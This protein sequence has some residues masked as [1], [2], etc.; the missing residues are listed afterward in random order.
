M[1]KTYFNRKKLV[2]Y[3]LE[4]NLDSELLSHCHDWIL[5]FSKVF[6]EVIVYSTHVGRF[7]LPK[8]VFVNPM[9]GGTLKKRVVAA[10]NLANSLK[11]VFKH[12]KNLVV[13]HHM[14][15]KTS[16]AIGFPIKLVG[17]PQGLWYSHSHAPISL[18]MSKHFVDYIFSSTPGAIP[19]NSRKNTYVGHA[20]AVPETFELNLEEDAREGFVSL[21]RVVPIKRLEELL[22]VISSLENIKASITFIG[23]NS[24]NR[25]YS[26]YLIDIAEKK[27][28]RLKFS[29]PIHHDNVF[30]SLQNF[31]IYFTG[32]PKSVDKATIEAAI[33]GCLLVTDS[34][35]ALE[36]TGMNSI[37]GEKRLDLSE[38]I[39]FILNMSTAQLMNARR[40]LSLISRERNDLQKTILKMTEKL[41]TN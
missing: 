27:D 32:T 1:N 9:G 3:N 22:F 19:I 11:L 28:L 38:Q 2:I 21:G 18:K 36:L 29:D 5:E 14:S 41:L 8:N 40:E 13:F 34:E 20:I 37:Y 31:S 12:R 16:A 17:V 10:F 7:E 6:E 35:S 24:V 4:T 30:K 23:S 15:A 33:S 25:E 26:S 39:K